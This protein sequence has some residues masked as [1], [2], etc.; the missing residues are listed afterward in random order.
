MAVFRC[1]SFAHRFLSVSKAAGYIVSINRSAGGVPKLPVREVFVHENGLDG[2]AHR[3]HLHGG[4]DK[5]VCV[6]S[7]ERIEALQR[8]G[9]PI[10]PGT[11]GE[12]VTISGV[13]WTLVAPRDRMQLGNVRIEITG[14]ATPCQTII[15]SFSDRKSVRISQKVFPGWSRVYGRVIETG[16]MCIGDSA[17]LELPS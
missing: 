11:T 12:N 15:A 10:A 8:E 13:D 16:I 1:G 7:A 3:F 4:L 14:Y 6:Y 17:V 5:A 2:D 9:H